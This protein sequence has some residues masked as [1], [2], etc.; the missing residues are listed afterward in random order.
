MILD[1]LSVPIV[2]AP[3]AG[4]PATPQLAAAASE[5]GGLGFL[6]SGYLTGDALRQRVAEIRELTAK[7][8]GVNVF[9]PGR[10]T[11]PEQFG[12]Y[13]AELVPEVRRAGVEPGEPRF[14]DDDWEAK[15]AWLRTD[16]VPVV[17][18]T[19]GCPAADVVSDLQRSGSE[20]WVTVTDVE[21]AAA[22]V[23]AGSDALVVQGSEAGGHRGSFID[24]SRNDLIDG[25]SLLSLLQ[26]LCGT[27]PVPMV[28]AG[29]LATGAGIAGILCAGAA[30]VQLG[31]AFLRCP[32][33]GT[34][35]VHR[36]AVAT[37]VPTGMTRAFTGR[38]ARGISNR[39]LAD[40]TRGAASGYPEIHHV[41]SPLRRAGLAS[42]DG[43]VVNLWAGQTHS[44]AR[45]L[46]AGDLVR[47]LDL[48]ARAA[49]ADLARR[50]PT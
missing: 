8:F 4:G 35:P 40:H 31:T 46:P 5:A 21:E 13:V 24:D 20:V 7:P 43:D 25:L 47:V 12:A 23:S 49:A 45:E 32:E 6:A 39:F 26:L 30:A 42:G 37:D 9:V 16:P 33:A 41:T 17:S 14:D 48:E 2:L 38:L 10:A 19:F 15:L 1:G 22:A 28:A 27:V 3:L 36:K 29:G 18:F 34:S 50:M 44:L 11:P